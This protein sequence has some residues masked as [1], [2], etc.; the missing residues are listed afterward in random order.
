[1]NKASKG[2]SLVELL[3]AIAILGI[4]AS[5]GL[6][7]AG[8]DRDQLQLDTAARRL[9]LGLERGRSLA[10]RQQ[11]ACG[12][13]LDAEGWLPSADDA[14]P[15]ELAACSG[16]GLALQEA[17][18]QGPI[19]LHTNLPPVLRIAANGLLIDGGTVVLSHG[20]LQRSR[21]L[22]VSLPLGISRLGLY[23]G[24]APAGGEA[25]SSSRCRPDPGEA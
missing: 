4:L 3:V 18:E 5:V 19:Q 17:L 6:V 9:Q 7:H 25:P 2:F 21:C 1:M 20:R 15:G 10:R 12:I 24:A 8:S 13:S 16:A 22:V 11:R 23:D 14:L